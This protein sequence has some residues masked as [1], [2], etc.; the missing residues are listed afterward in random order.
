M[1]K[2]PQLSPHCNPITLSHLVFSVNPPLVSLLLQFL[3][4]VNVLFLNKP[5]YGQAGSRATAQ[6]ATS[7]EAEMLGQSSATLANALQKSCFP[8]L[9]LPSSLGI[10][11]VHW[12]WLRCHTASETR[13][14]RTLSRDS[15]QGHGGQ[16]G[17]TGSASLALNNHQ[18]SSSQTAWL[19]SQSAH[20][21]GAH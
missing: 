14:M 13:A 18:A 5:P 3:L 16:T 1:C 21:P 15:Q 9:G 2:L 11:S 12:A 7:W 10:C 6:L 4:L 20:Y 17:P 8:L 19:C